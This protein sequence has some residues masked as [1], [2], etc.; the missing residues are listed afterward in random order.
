MAAMTDTKHTPTSTPE[1]M[2]DEARKLYA[3]ARMPVRWSQA[4][5]FDARERMK[6]KADDLMAR[7]ALTAAA[8]GGAP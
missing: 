4:S 2:I 3:F 6:R 5:A 7:A 1:E 8:E